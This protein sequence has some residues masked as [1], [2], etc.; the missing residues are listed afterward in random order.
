M[1]IHA[2]AGALNPEVMGVI[3]EAAK[4]TRGRA[5]DDSHLI[6]AALR[7]SGVAR[8][9]TAI[10]V[11]VARAQAGVSKVIEA[12][13]KR[14]W[15]QVDVSLGKPVNEAAA[16][17]KAAGL[18]DLDGPHLFA[19]LLEAPRSRGAARAL[20]EA[21]FSLRQY[22]W[23]LAHGTAT[24]G[25]FPAAGPVT[26]TLHND[27]F[28]P[29]ALVVEVLRDIFGRDEQTAKELMM[30]VHRE[31]SASLATMEATEARDRVTRARER[32]RRAEMPLRVTVAARG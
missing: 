27:P 7:L 22:R 6:L 18:A 3:V 16:K 14:P 1:F 13:P 12:L 11:D 17:A 19:S 15:Y 30:R 28:T 8:A 21:G 10:G 23:H 9:L 32:A 4:S 20:E 2:N 25:A 5:V 31:G 24:E 26:V 29:M